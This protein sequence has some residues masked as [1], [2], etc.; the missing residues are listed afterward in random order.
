MS[1]LVILQML[2]R[3]QNECAIFVLYFGLQVF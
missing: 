1:N 2:I 3:Y